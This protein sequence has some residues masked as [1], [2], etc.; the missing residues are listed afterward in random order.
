[1]RRLRAV[2]LAAI[3]SAPLATPSVMRAAEPP[4]PAA[5]DAD[6][7]EFLGS[8]DDADADL[9]DY[10]AQ[11]AEPPARDSKAGPKLGSSRP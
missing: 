7:L 3:C 9:Q 2:A 6:L 11:P 10:L 8:T 4:Q 5:P 1:V